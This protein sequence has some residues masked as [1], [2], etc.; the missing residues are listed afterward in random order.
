MRRKES[1]N[2]Y[3]LDRLGWG[4]IG[5]DGHL[6]RRDILSN[7]QELLLDDVQ[8]PF[9]SG[10]CLGH[11]AHTLVQEEPFWMEETGR[12]GELG[13][14][15]QSRKYVSIIEDSEVITAVVFL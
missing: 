10:Y 5:T 12:E 15:S 14:L 11:E 3:L 8:R 7:S 6:R 1:G 13:H 4:W 2:D 9:M